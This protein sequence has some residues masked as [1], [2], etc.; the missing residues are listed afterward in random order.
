[1]LLKINQFR[2]QKGYLSCRK[3]KKK[4][5]L[6]YWL[7]FVWIDICNLDAWIQATESY[8]IKLNPLIASRLKSRNLLCIARNFGYRVYKLRYHRFSTCFSK[9]H[10]YKLVFKNLSNVKRYIYNNFNLVIKDMIKKERY[11]KKKWIF[12]RASLN[13]FK[14]IHMMIFDLATL[15]R[16]NRNK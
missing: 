4:K 12:S 6:E 3:K 14:S 13:D 9:H 15:V 2:Y 8:C 5:L 11:Q 1:M 7:N 16:T 10:I